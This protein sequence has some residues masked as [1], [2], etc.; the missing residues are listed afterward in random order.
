MATQTPNKNQ[1]Q[2]QALV[3]IVIM[4]A[5]LVCV[6]VLASY[7][8]TGLDLT[9]EKRFTLSTPTKKLLRNMPEVAVVDVYLQGKFPAELQRLQEA[10]RE[11]LRSFKDIAGNKVI[12]RFTNPLEGK[13]ESDQKLIAQDL[14]EKGIWLRQL[15]TKD[16]DEEGYSM[17]VFFPYALVQYNG[18]EM[19][20]NLLENHQ[21]SF[22]QNIS[23]AE[24]SLEYKF[25][26]AINQLGRRDRAR[27]AYLTGNNEELG[28]QTFDMLHTISANYTLDTVDLS[29]IHHPISIAY[30]AVIINEPTIP[31]IGPDKLKIDQYVMRGGHVLWIVNNLNVSLD[32][33]VH[34]PQTIA[35]EYGLNLDDILFK[36]GV[37]V[38][39]DLI[40]DRQDLPL[41]RTSEGTSQVEM[42]EWVYFPRLN[43][44]S[45]HPIVK[46]M[47]FLMSGFTNSIDTIKASG[48]KKTILLHSSKYSLSARSP[49][50]VSLS[51]MNYPLKNEMFPK[52]YLPVAVLLEGKFHSVYEHKLAPEYLHTLDSLKDTFKP[53][54]DSNTSMIV[55]SAGNIFNNDYTAKDGVLPIG[56][57]KY[58]GD[59]FANKDFLLNCLEYLTDN[60]GI[61]EARSKD[62][63]L[64]LL[65]TGRAKDEK[66]MWQFVNVAIPIAMV[67]VFASAYFFFRKRRYEVKNNDKVKPAS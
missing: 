64:R 1:R 3:R 28:I 47:D 45:D 48:I 22:A 63:K 17:K 10:V 26:N 36:Y 11:C 16:D 4:A 35:L 38:N 57:Y 66:T 31:F 27:I 9:S 46:N 53:K 24:A 67:L 39:N 19:A 37:R 5:I 12:F 61:L 58:T 7:F 32:S 56:Y 52:S 40:E 51:M 42:H 43:P 21:G 49:V 18:K 54:T 2:R 62:V 6:N 44:T 23:Y 33:L 60:S 20:V 65:D 34:S 14:S 59:F 41:P 15:P 13:S 55:I 29:R 8:H 50:R 25:A 30:D